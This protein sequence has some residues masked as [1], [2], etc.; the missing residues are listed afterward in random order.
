MLDA[1]PPAPSRA[2]GTASELSSRPAACGTAKSVSVD[3]RSARSTREPVQRPRP[4]RAL[5]S[6]LS[7]ISQRTSGLHVAPEVGGIDQLA[8]KRLVEPLCLREGE[9][10]GQEAARDADEPRLV[11]DPCAKPPQPVVDDPRVVEGQLGERVDRV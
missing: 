11:G 9:R 7:G 1:P 3:A 6:P 2:P 4:S 10:L 5:C 8:A